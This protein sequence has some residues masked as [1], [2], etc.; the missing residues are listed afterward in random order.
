LMVGW[1]GPQAT[2]NVNCSDM[3]GPAADCE[4]IAAAEIPI[5]FTIFVT[6]NW[7]GVE[8]FVKEKR[9]IPSL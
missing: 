5:L 9:K 7:L 6:E 3:F 2:L 8:K 4:P 1:D